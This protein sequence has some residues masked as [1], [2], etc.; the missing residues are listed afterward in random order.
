MDKIA[1]IRLSSLGDIIL[2]ESV[3]R[4]LKDNFPNSEITFISRESYRPV[5]EMFPAIDKLELLQIPGKHENL[6]ELKKHIKTISQKFDLVIDLHKNIRSRVICRK[7]KAHKKLSYKKFRLQRQIAVWFKTRKKY[8][9]TAAKYMT[10]LEQLKLRIEHTIPELKVSPSQRKDAAKYLQGINFEKN[11]YAILAVG[12]SYPPK[13][14]PLA[15]FAEIAELLNKKY[16]LKI[17][18]VDD[19][20]FDISAFKS[21]ISGGVLQTAVG[22]DLKLLAGLLWQSKVTVS[23]DSGVMHLSAALHTPTL[24]L[25]GPTHPVLGFGP[26]GDYSA[27]LST[28]AFCS[29]CSVHGQRKCFWKKQY[30]FTKMPL[31]MIETALKAI[32]R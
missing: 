22:L 16:G 31:E 11:R 24:G 6:N 27:G 18:V 19:M 29:P 32:L 4:S 13:K 28:D 8:V 17:L 1:I 20:D 12:A 10:P 15:R 9:P 7:L 30:C 25:F 26:C 3:T 2:T 21:L 5:L 23:N 14:F